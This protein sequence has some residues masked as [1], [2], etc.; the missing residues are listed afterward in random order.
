MVKILSF[1][2]ALFLVCLPMAAS[3]APYIDGS[4]TLILS[5][6]YCGSYLPAFG[7][8]AYTPVCDEWVNTVEI[9]AIKALRIEAAYTLQFAMVL[10]L[11]WILIICGAA[12]MGRWLFRILTHYRPLI[13]R[14]RR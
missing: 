11:R 3:A 9:P 5:H 13:L 14:R 6:S 8:G 7:T 1:I 12:L 4:G 2:G 10:L